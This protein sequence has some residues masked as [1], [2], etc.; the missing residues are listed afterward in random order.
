MF[1][2]KKKKI[3]TPGGS[4]PAAGTVIQGTILLWN[5]D[6]GDLP[7]GWEVLSISKDKFVMGEISY[8]DYGNTGGAENHYHEYSNPTGNG[9]DNHT[10]AVTITSIETSDGWVD[11]QDIKNDISITDYS[12]EFHSHSNP[13]S[14]YTLSPPVHAHEIKDTETAVNLPKYYRLYYILATEN[15]LKIPNGAIL[16]WDGDIGDIP[17]E[18]AQCNGYNSTPDLRD[19]YI[20]GADIDADVDN[21]GSGSHTHVNSDTESAQHRHKIYLVTGAQTVNAKANHGSGT[22]VPTCDHTHTKSLYS[23]YSGA[24]THS[25]PN[26]ASAPIEP[27]YYKLHHIMA[28]E[29]VASFDNKLIIGW[30]KSSIPSGWLLCDGNNGTPNLN[31]KFIRCANTDGDL[32]ET[33]GSNT[34]QH[35]GNSNVGSDGAGVHSHSTSSN[36]RIASTSGSSETKTAEPWPYDPPL[37]NV[38]TTGHTHEIEFYLGSGTEGNHSHSMPD[39]ESAEAIPPY[40]KIRFIVKI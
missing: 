21:T 29:E 23:L 5:G 27:P 37:Q 12:D 26:T 19:Q 39:T 34:H 9:G 33:G 36:K 22:L 3:Y 28:T 18:Y 38:T 7:S 6:E 13:G 30:S 14:S 35:T 32:G 17:E 20:Y 11:T 1:I 8:E 2:V 10:H 40:V 15:E 4:P 16:W 25:I 31:D 24:H